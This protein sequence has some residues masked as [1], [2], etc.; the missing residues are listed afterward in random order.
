[1]TVMG[2]NLSMLF[3]LVRNYLVLAE[4]LMDAAV[5]AYWL[6]VVEVLKERLD[7]LV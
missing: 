3:S 4:V 6:F 2:L 7:C 5:I 1:M